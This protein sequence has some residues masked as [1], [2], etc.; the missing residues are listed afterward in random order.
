MAEKISST[1]SDSFDETAHRNN[2][3]NAAV[4]KAG[5]CSTTGQSSSGQ[6][7]L[8]S[9]EQKQKIREIHAQG[10]AIPKTIQSEP[11]LEEFRKSLL[12]KKRQELDS[13]LKKSS[14]IQRK[15]S[16]GSSGPAIS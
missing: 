3:Q 16:T 7:P 11:K 15:P 13:A 4:G 2:E 10:R 14:E 6:Q 5:E 8:T 9:E 12:Q 1:P